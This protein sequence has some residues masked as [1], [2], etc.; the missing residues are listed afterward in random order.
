MGLH[1]LLQGQLTY[2]IGGWV[3]PRAGL[4]AVEERKNLLLLPGI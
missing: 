4:D 3:T 2:W 1:G